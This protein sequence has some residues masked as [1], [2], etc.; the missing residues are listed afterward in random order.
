MLKHIINCSIKIWI[1][2]NLW[3]R[4]NFY[5]NISIY[6][7]ITLLCLKAAPTTTTFLFGSIKA[8]STAYRDNINDLPKPRLAINMGN[9][10]FHISLK[11][12]A[13]EG[14]SW[15]LRTSL[16]I[17]E[18]YSTIYTHQMWPIKINCPISH[19]F[20]WILSMIWI[21]FI[22]HKAEMCWRGSSAYR[23]RTGLF[24]L[25]VLRP[26]W[27]TCIA[28]GAPPILNKSFIVHWVLL[29]REF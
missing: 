20:L 16:Q 18:R 21:W 24:E 10:L 29:I 26:N 14:K 5:S 28:D 7:K 11:N 15:T 4:F 9:F 12:K 3:F 27:I 22:C 1:R 13:C 8:L 23:K 25:P 6:S 19:Q 17:K 2:F